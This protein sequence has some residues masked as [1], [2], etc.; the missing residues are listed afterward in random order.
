MEEIVDFLQLN[1]R[2]SNRPEPYWRAARE[3]TRLSDWLQEK[4]QLW[5][6]RFPDFDDT[7]KNV[8]FSF[9]SFIYTLLPKNYFANV[10]AP[11]NDTIRREDWQ[12]YGRNLH[13]NVNS[14]M[15]SLPSH[16]QLLTALRAAKPPN[17]LDLLMPSLAAGGRRI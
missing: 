11:L 17:P 3:E 9:Q 12:A 2:T 13:T 4:M 6:I 5:R 10:K 16:H 15:G 8:L 7:Y 1:Y 14:M